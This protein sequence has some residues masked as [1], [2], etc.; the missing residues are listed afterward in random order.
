MKQQIRIV[1]LLASMASAETAMAYCWS[2]ES[3]ADHAPRYACFGPDQM[4]TS[5]YI[6]ISD[7]LFAVGCEQGVSN[8]PLSEYG[9]SKGQ[10]FDCKTSLGYG[11]NSPAMIRKWLESKK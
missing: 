6:A 8:S 3:R 11:E 9:M 4:T 2:W 7:A 1:L 5:A 10:W